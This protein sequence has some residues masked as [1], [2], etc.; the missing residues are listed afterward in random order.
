M[1]GNAVK[2]HWWCTEFGELEKNN[3][4]SAFDGR[5]FSLGTETRKFEQAFAKKLEVPFAVATPSGTASLTMALM[6][7]GIEP[8]DEVIVPALT[9]IATAQ[10]AAIL[11]VKVVLVD[12]L[13]N[14]PLL[15]PDE[16]RKKI[17]PATKAII[18]VHYNGRPCLMDELFALGRQNGITII[19]D[20]CKAM[21]SCTPKG[22]LGTIGEMGCY[23]LGLVS[24]ISTCYGGVVVT[25]DKEMYNRLLLIRDHGIIRG[26]NEKYQVMG[27][28]FKF[29]D[30]LAAMGIAQINRLDE[31]LNH[32]Y[33]VYKRYE[34]GLASLPFIKIIP[35]DIKMGQVPLL[36]DVESQYA[37]E[38]ITYLKLHDIETVRLHPPLH[39]AAYFNDNDGYPYATRFAQEGFNLPCGPSQPLEN[40]DRCISLLH[41]WGTQIYPTLK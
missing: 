28:N 2:I 10:A 6:A 27:F 32:L 38:I 33:E 8:G 20:A 41:E 25:R 1:M 26:E 23:S 19:E 21:F 30:L 7:A 29:S 18:P 17:T 31:K 5:H 4:I 15:D 9:W 37:T 12:C 39:H 34:I 36:I 14:S 24:L 16:V 35:V 13:P 3:I 11:G 22:Y 40:V